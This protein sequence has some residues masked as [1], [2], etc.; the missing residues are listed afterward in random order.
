MSNMSYCRFQNTVRDLS[1]CQDA[2]ETLFGGEEPLS[3]EELDAA[4]RL[5]ACCANIIQLVG[6]QYGLDIDLDEFDN[7]SDDILDEANNEAEG[8]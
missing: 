7:N 3:K 8:E 2:L 1:E 6:D 5:V 4:K